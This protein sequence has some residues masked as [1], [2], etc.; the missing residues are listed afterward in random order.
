MAETPDQTILPQG[1]DAALRE[2]LATGERTRR[3]LPLQLRH[4]IGFA[5]P[6]L[7]DDEIVAR[8]RGLLVHLTAQIAGDRPA[9]AGNANYRIGRD[10]VLR[11]VFAQ[12]AFLAHCHALALEF[13]LT[14]RLASE[15]DIDLMLPPIMQEL[16]ASPNERTSRL[17]SSSVAAQGRFL[18]DME[19]MQMPLRQ[20]P[21]ELL[22]IA[23]TIGRECLGDPVLADAVEQ[24]VR[25]SYDE[26]ATRLVLLER[27]AHASDYP[28]ARGLQLE[29]AGVP[30]FVAGLASSIGSI[31]CDAVLAT[32]ESQVARLALTLRTLGCNPRVVN[33]NLLLLH[34]RASLAVAAA[35]DPA[36]ASLLLAQSVAGPA[37]DAA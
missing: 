15:A 14:R 16:I 26:G 30:L 10:A 27:L 6:S 4:R 36:T 21:A 29:Q 37:Q 33:R 28:R 25:T 34:D 5:D 22:N 23:L 32:T 35:I 31:Y 3:D 2:L 11:A 13:R 19:R 8:A 17:A 12:P 9:G 1:R 20:L 7:F 24:A 18:R